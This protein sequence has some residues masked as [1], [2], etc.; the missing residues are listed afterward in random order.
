MLEGASATR[1]FA[2]SKPSRQAGANES[3]GKLPFGSAE[4]KP[5]SKRTYANSDARFTDAKR[6]R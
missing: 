6:F 3:G 2:E 5:H 1:G 4:D